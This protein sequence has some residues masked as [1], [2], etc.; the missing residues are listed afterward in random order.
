M[1]EFSENI[2]F[3]SEN[4]QKSK[5]KKPTRYVTNR[6]VGQTSWRFRPSLF[7]RFLKFQAIKSSKVLGSFRKLDFS[8]K[9][10]KRRL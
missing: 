6:W 7:F 2:V 3:H 1:R 10:R 5:A 9:A 4:S 8:R